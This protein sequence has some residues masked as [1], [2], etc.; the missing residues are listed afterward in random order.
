MGTGGPAGWAVTKWLRVC[1]LLLSGVPRACHAPATLALTAILLPTTLVQLPFKASV[2]RCN[3]QPETGFLYLRVRVSSGCCNQV[4]PAGFKQGTFIPSQ[5]WRPE[6]LNRGVS[7]A[8]PPLI[9]QVSS[10]LASSQLLVAA[11]RP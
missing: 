3:L 1:S 7:R 2:A 5:F 10:F 8:M 4:T 6:A 11:A 9:L